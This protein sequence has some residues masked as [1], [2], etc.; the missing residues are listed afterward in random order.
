M[1]RVFAIDVAQTMLEHVGVPSDAP[2]PWLAPTEVD[3][4]KTVSWRRDGARATRAGSVEKSTRA[5]IGRPPLRDSY[6]RG[7]ER[8]RRQHVAA[9]FLGFV[10]EASA[11][12]HGDVVAE[13]DES[14]GASSGEFDD[15]GADESRAAGTC[16]IENSTCPLHPNYAGSINETQPSQ[17]ACFQRAVDWRAYCG[18]PTNPDYGT[19]ATWLP[20]TNIF[21]NYYKAYSPGCEVQTQ[22]CPKNPAFVNKRFYDWEPAVASNEAY[23]A[24]GARA[25]E[26]AD[27]CGF[28][29]TEGSVYTMYY[30]PLTGL[31]LT[32]G[33]SNT[34]Y[35]PRAYAKGC[36][37]WNS[38]CVNFPSAAG[39]F[40][41]TY[42][43]A[44]TSYAACSQRASDYVQW[45]GGTDPG[46]DSS[47]AQYYTGGIGG[48][49][50]LPSGATT[51]R[52]AK[53]CRITNRACPN[54]PEYAYK[55]FADYYNNA[56]NDSAACLQRAQDFRGWCG[57]TASDWTI[58]EYTPY[59]GA[60]P[61]SS[62]HVYTH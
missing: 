31:T 56:G 53:G 1:Q 17:A 16:R 44:G 59:T 55:T 10:M 54:H 23:C 25:K 57:G 18:R 42:N 19:T 14:D 13:D 45:C 5:V 60:A 34:V 15:D 27:W 3:D 33:G 36:L 39:N 35:G 20:N 30:K 32:P 61:V 21:T 7:I 47:R 22:A 49:N 24:G 26:F 9:A 40:P 50:Y 2:E 58:A 29:D 4:Q 46:R 28:P 6:G 37:I 43:G 51:D 52:H 8:M 38:R 41:D 48:T 11:C 12:S 62:G